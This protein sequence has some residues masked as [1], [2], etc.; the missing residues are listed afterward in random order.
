MMKYLRMI[1]SCGLMLVFSVGYGQDKD[2]RVKRNKTNKQET[3]SVSNQTDDAM[4]DTVLRLSDGYEFIITQEEGYVQ[5]EKSYQLLYNSKGKKLGEYNIRNKPGEKNPLYGEV[6]I[7]G[8][9]FKT[10]PLNRAMISCDNQ[11][12]LVYGNPIGQHVL[13]D[14][15]L[16][17]FTVNGE[18]QTE[19]KLVALGDFLIE[20]SRY[21]NIYYTG[22]DL[23]RSQI[24]LSKTNIT[25]KR[26]WFTELPFGMPVFL[27]VS[28]DEEQVITAVQV[29]DIE[30]KLPLKSKIVLLVFDV[31]GGCIYHINNLHSLTQIRHISICQNRYMVIFQEHG[32]LTIDLND[33]YKVLNAGGLDG[34]IFRSEQVGLIESDG[35]FM[36]AYRDHTKKD[37]CSLQIIDCVSG[38]KLRRMEFDYVDESLKIGLSVVDESTFRVYSNQ[39]SVIL[40]KSRK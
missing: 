1:F 11:S 8:A 34:R 19:S 39:N 12:V 13:S 33:G 25:G 40:T 18:L 23:E 28:T 37:R 29:Q 30:S 35:V 31:N 16:E 7:G 5:Q 17:L 21:G 22:W 32:W 27:G 3:Q 36:V 10:S 2:K 6:T 4:L 24:Q 38:V 15:H 20:S 26:K 14:L 9:T